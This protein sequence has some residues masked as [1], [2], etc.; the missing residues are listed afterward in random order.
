M[1]KA[2]FALILAAVSATAFAK[3]PPLNDE[4]KAKADEAK[5]KTAHTAKAE[6]YLLC[7][8]QD[9]VAAHVQKTNKAQAGKPVATAPC[10]DPGKFVYTPPEAAAPVAAASAPAVAAAP[11]APAKK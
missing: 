3:L 10:A 4:A 11:A 5:A 2:L 8:S 9:K 1:N 7:K 6:A